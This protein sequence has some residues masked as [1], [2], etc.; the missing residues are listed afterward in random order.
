MEYYS[1]VCGG[2][3]LLEL[4]VACCNKSQQVAGAFLAAFIG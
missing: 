3:V 4:C 2:N 1:E